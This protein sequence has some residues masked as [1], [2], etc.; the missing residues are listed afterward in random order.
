M[1]IKNGG[2]RAYFEL[3]SARFHRRGK[4]GNEISIRWDYSTQDPHSHK[5]HTEHYKIRKFGVN[6]A[7]I[8]G[9]IAIRKPENLLRNVLDFLSALH[10]F[11]SEF[12]SFCLAVSRSILDR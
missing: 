6:Q 8:E 4:T 1:K 11:L 12:W 10:T 5:M 9:D 3:I 7:N 2:H